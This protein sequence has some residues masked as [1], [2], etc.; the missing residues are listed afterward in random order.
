MFLAQYIRCIKNC[1]VHAWS[2]FSMYIGAC[3]L[4]T[5]THTLSLSLSVIVFVCKRSKVRLLTVYIYIYAP[6]SNV[7]DTFEFSLFL[8]MT[9]TTIFH[10]EYVFISI[11]IKYLLKINLHLQ[12]LYRIIGSKSLTEYLSQ[13]YIISSSC[14][15][16]IC[17]TI[18]NTS[19]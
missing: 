11:R 17:I 10:Y 12:S 3:K 19:I 1:T 9:L 15:Q 4:H 13:I 14:H 16:R 2:L 8:G 5:L 18:F 7:F 6:T